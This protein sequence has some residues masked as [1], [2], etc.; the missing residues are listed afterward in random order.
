MCVV[1]FLDWAT[2]EPEAP[3]VGALALP[4]VVFYKVKDL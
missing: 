3:N 2:S 1:W 4:I